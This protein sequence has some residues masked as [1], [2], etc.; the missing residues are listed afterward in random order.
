MSIFSNIVRFFQGGGFMMYPIAA[1]LVLGLA[2]A[3]ERWV[4]LTVTA[5]RNR[6]LWDEISPFL[7]QGNFRQAV[8]L[9]SKS[10]A[11]IGQILSYGLVRASP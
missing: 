6:G 9:T 10:R 8:Q 7:A 2:I 3:I 11:A 5:L 1:V 4:Y